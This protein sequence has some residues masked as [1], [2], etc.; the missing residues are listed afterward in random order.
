MEEN[1]KVDLTDYI[2]KQ[3]QGE[4]EQGQRKQEPEKEYHNLVDEVFTKDDD[5]TLLKTATSEEHNP[6]VMEWLRRI[7]SKDTKVNI[8]D[9]VERLQHKAEEKQREQERENTI[10]DLRKRIDKLN[11][12]NAKLYSSLPSKQSR[13]AP[14]FAEPCETERERLG[15]WLRGITDGD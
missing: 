11:K 3:S 9:F 7:T 5:G 1:M 2:E 4:T 8:N 14:S 10:N 15:E 6:E 12:G 13:V